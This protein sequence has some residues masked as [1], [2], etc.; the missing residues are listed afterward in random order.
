MNTYRRERKA[1]E[2]D[3]FKGVL[4]LEIIES[5]LVKKT[6]EDAG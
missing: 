5:D 2:L 6:N 4:L 1:R 3:I